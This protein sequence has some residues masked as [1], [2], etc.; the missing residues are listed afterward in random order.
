[1][2]RTENRPL[3]AGRLTALEVLLVGLVLGAVGVAY[4]ALALPKPWAAVV[5]GF[6]FASYVFVYT[7]LKRLTTLNTLVGAIPGALP[8]VIGWVAAGGS[9]GPGVL[10]LFAILFLWQVPHFLAIAWIYREDYARAGLQMLPVFDPDG[11][12]TGRF[13]VVY[14]LALLAASLGPVMLG[15][16]GLLYLTGAVVLGVSFL[17]SALRFWRSSSSEQARRVLKASLLYL[18]VLLALLLLD[19]LTTPIALAFWM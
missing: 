2:H 14:C 10:A 18:P 13:M 1:M 17:T 16:A 9:L 6:T 11:R 12:L 8:P 5:A 19:A 3:P 7:P 4:L 15:G